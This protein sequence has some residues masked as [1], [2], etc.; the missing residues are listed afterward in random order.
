MP[1]VGLSLEEFV[2]RAQLIEVGCYEIFGIRGALEDDGERAVVGPGP[3][4]VGEFEVTHELS[5][6]WG[7]G[8]PRFLVRLGASVTCEAG[9]VRVGVQAEYELDGLLLDDVAPD[10]EEEYVNNVSVMTLVPY[11]REAVAA[12]SLRTLDQPITLGVVQRGALR[13]TS[14][15][16]DRS[17]QLGRP[18]GDRSTPHRGKSRARVE[19]PD[20]T[21][22]P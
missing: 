16:R 13:F 17:A 3:L 6:H 5:V 7:D 8:D 4:E 21:P 2:K 20:T 1:E 14:P 22:S 9:E 18:D 11:L 12:A 19:R 15:R 10:V